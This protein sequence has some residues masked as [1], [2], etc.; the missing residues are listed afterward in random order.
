MSDP[1]EAFE[2]NDQIENN[3]DNADPAANFL[4]QQQ[5]EMAKIENNDFDTFGDF[6]MYFIKPKRKIF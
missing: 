2:S 1:F 5:A 6:C 4:A 3:N